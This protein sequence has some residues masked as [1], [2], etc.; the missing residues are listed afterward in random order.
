M[1]T[2]RVLRRDQRGYTLTELLIT[3]AILGLVMAAVLAVQMTSNTMF[4]RGENQAEAQQGARAAMLMEEDLRM[5]GYGCPD[6]G[7]PT[8]PPLG[9]QQKITAASAT[10]ITFWADTLNAST[11]LAAAVGAGAT[12]L[13]VTDASGIAVNDRIYLFPC[14]SDLPPCNTT[15]P[16]PNWET[17]V[18]TAIAGTN[19]TVAALTNA[20]PQGALVGRPRQITYSFA[21]GTLSKNAGDGNGLQILATGM[22]SL[23]FAFYNASNAVISSDPLLPAGVTLTAT[24][25]ASVGRIKIQTTTQSTTSAAGPTTYTINTNVRPRNL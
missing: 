16:P 7:C 10:A 9:N 18:V 13:P 17:R 11:T 24:Q 23:A 1:K 6:N 25:L 4:L 8:P 22:Q 21:D 3:V 2:L 15:P 14:R 19:L 12:T 5:A 20:Y